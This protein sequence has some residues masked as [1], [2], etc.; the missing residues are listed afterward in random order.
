MSLVLTGGFFTT[1]SPEKPIHMTIFG[2]EM[3][4]ADTFHHLFLFLKKQ[5][6]IEYIFY[7]SRYVAKVA[8]KTVT[9]IFPLLKKTTASLVKCGLGH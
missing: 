8:H 1:D 4:V 5:L 6:F 9:V 2:F 7:D 3:E